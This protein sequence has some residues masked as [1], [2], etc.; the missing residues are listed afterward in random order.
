MLRLSL[1]LIFVL[2][3]GCG[4]A[5]VPQPA[6]LITGNTHTRC[7]QI[8]KEGLQSNE[9]W[10]SIY[11]AEALI[12]AN[13]EFDAQPVLE[14]RL[15]NE[16]DSRRQAGYLRAL[17]PLAPNGSLIQLQNI[18]LGSDPAAS[19]LAAEAM[20]YYG[21]IGDPGILDQIVQN[22]TNG[23]LK[24]YLAAALTRADRANF[25]DLIREE[26][27]GNNPANRY[28]AADVIPLLGKP[29]QDVAILLDMQDLASSDFE[30]FYFTRALAMFGVL[31][32]RQ[33]LGTLL[34]HSDVTIRSRAAFAVA[35]SWLLEEVTTLVKL[36]DDPTLSVRVRAAQALLTLSD[37]ESPYRYLNMRYNRL[38][39]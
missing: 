33:N 7:I 29:D 22:T 16:V 34:N 12:Q 27:S 25:R 6:Y 35:E 26:L 11:A 28:T 38:F 39:G 10:P 1:L 4:S 5:K 30:Q 18:V 14:S 36:L 20:F 17:L 23:R 21:R 8:L 19:V 13:F 31:S 15:Q 32:A 24:V 9:Y 3:S 2:L 37:P